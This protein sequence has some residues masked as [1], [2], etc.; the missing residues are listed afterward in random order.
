MTFLDILG[1]VFVVWFGYRGF[2]K[3]FIGEVGYLVGLIGAIFFS[4]TWYIKLGELLSHW[5]PVHGYT[6]IILAFSV[7]FFP[8]LV[9]FRFLFKLIEFFISSSGL[10]SINKWGGILTGLIKGV[11]ILSMTIWSL[12]L[13]NN[14]K[15]INVVQSNFKY[16]SKLIIIRKNVCNHFGWEDPVLQGKIYLEKWLN[17]EK[18]NN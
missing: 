8:S 3:G 1:G 4:L 14:S 16:G 17:K 13:F 18:K 6:L 5:I 9:M 12:E 11:I 7:I 2:N 15:W 10:L